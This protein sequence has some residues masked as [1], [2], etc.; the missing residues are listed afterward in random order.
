MARLSNDIW[1]FDDPFGL[2]KGK[3]SKSKQPKENTGMWDMGF[4]TSAKGVKVKGGN[5]FSGMNDNYEGKPNRQRPQQKNAPST[6]DAMQ[7]TFSMFSG[8]GGK[9]KKPKSIKSAGKTLYQDPDDNENYITQEQYDS[10]KKTSR[11]KQASNVVAKVVGGIKKFQ[12]KR[13]V[14]KMQPHAHFS[15]KPAKNQYQIQVDHEGRN[16]SEIYNSPNEAFNAQSKWRGR[17]ANVSHIQ[18]V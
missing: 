8:Y 1:D 7:E 16:F 5:M 4:P 18:M 2:K 3:K 14:K 11:P 10:R 6:I 9:E 15:K 13:K 12:D 17:G